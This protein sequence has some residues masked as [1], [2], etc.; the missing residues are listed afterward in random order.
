MPPQSA[1]P[2]TCMSGMAC[3][4][5]RTHWC[6]GLLASDCQNIARKFY[7]CLIA[8]GHKPHRMKKLM[9]KAASRLDVE[10]TTKP[11]PKDKNI[12][13]LLVFT[14]EFHSRGLTRHDVRNHC[15]QTVV[16]L[17]PDCDMIDAQT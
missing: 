11:Q 6:N 2:K 5:L 1:H 13:N 9:V 15:T 7:E 4:M 17:V 3:S 14:H 10:P 16:D 8:V 12:K